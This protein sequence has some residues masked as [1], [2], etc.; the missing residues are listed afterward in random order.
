MLESWTLD[1]TASLGKK[2]RLVCRQDAVGLL[3][4]MDACEIEHK[5]GCN[6]LA[7][8]SEPL[9]FSLKKIEISGKQVVVKCIRVW[10]ESLNY[11][12]Q[13]DD[14]MLG[15]NIYSCVLPLAF[16]ENFKGLVVGVV[17]HIDF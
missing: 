10:N 11:E 6:L 8:S 16:K 7:T 1:E 3:F 2:T 14:V 17:L 4:T 9:R 12:K 15:K 5:R 13:G